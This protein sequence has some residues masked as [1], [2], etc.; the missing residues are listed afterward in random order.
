MID[1]LIKNYQVRT[2]VSNVEGFLRI[3][4][5]EITRFVIGARVRNR[6][7]GKLVNF[8]LDLYVNYCNLFAVTRL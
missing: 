7:H 3:G 1:K 4:L 2:I 8:L 6:P 5:G